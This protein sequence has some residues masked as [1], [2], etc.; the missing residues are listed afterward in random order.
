[1][2][3][4]VVVHEYAPVREGVNQVGIP[5][6]RDQDPA[7]PRVTLG[8]WLGLLAVYL[9]WDVIVQKNRKVGEVVD[10][11]NIRTNL[12]N[13]VWVGFAAVIFLNGMKVLLVK[14]AAW[15]IPGLSWLAEKLVPLFQV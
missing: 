8:F 11:K 3:G 12:Y 6:D 13:L 14:L 2:R 9:I 7:R 10:S 5:M 15:N 4:N 1:M